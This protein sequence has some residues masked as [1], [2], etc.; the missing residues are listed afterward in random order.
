MT[1]NTP[2]EGVETTSAEGEFVSSALALAAQELGV[3]SDQLHWQLDKSHFRSEQGLVVAQDTVRI[4]AWKRDEKE[5]ESCNAGKAW[6]QEVLKGMGLTGSIKA[7]MQ[8]AEKVILSVDVDQ[9]ARLIG[10]GGDTL[11]GVSELLDA[12]MADAFPGI[13]FHISVAD[14]REDRGDDRRGGRDR[15]DRGGR[16]RDRGRGRDRDDRGG[17]DR[18][19]DR[20]DRG[21]RDRDRDRGRDRDRDDRGGRTSERDEVALQSMARKMAERVLETGEAEQVRRTL[22]S[23]NRRIVHMTIKEVEGVGSRSLGEGNDKTIELYR[24]D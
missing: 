7:K 24:E 6:L 2:P 19:R 1:M 23:Y 20:D 8:S 5:L 10:R 17:R 22:N 3:E 18:D 15:D 13:V 12:T 16:D 9:A 21:G 4:V 14:K 11:K